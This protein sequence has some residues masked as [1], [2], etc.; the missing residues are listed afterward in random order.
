MRSVFEPGRPI[1]LLLWAL[2][3]LL[4]LAM[5]FFF[6]P[7]AVL[8]LAPIALAAWYNGRIP[9]VIFAV[10]LPLV[11]YGFTLLWQPGWGPWTQAFPNLFTRLF[12][13]ILFAV[14]IDFIARQNRALKQEI[15]VLRGILP[16]CAACK[17]IRTEDAHWEQIEQY[18]S[19]HSDARFTHSLCPDC[20][21]KQYEALEAADRGEFGRRKEDTY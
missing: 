5:D 3:A 11:R 13:F 9:A 12:I 20:E 16:I 21:K 7:L 6:G 4:V 10:S 18:I 1:L 17:K 19:E 15:K 14:L 2:L 8:Y